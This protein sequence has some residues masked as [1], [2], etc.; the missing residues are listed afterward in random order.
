MIKPPA[1]DGPSQ[2]ETC[3]F[4][5]KGEASVQCL[6]SAR[7]GLHAELARVGGRVHNCPAHDPNRGLRRVFEV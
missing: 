3:R 2:C 6:A 4:A 1:T 7:A 5:K